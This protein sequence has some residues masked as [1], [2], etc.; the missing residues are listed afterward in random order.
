MPGDSSPLG[1]ADLREVIAAIE[2]ERWSHWQ[3]Y[4]HEQCLVNEDG[5][6]TI[7]AELVDRWARQMN[8]PYDALTEKEKDSDREQADAYLR[9]LRP[10]ISRSDISPEALR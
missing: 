10:N 4:L 3:R 7:P 1:D 2:H 5:S 8:T 9:E 6:L